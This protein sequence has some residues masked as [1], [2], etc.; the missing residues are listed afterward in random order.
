MSEVDKIRSIVQPYLSGD[1]V[2][3]GFGGN[4]VNTTAIC[5]DLKEPY[6]NYGASRHL[7]G[8]ARS[9]YWFK[10]GVL[11]YVFSSH[12]LEDFPN[13]K[14]ILVEW[15]RVI[16]IGGT[17]ALYLPDERKYSRVLKETGGRY[18]AHHQIGNMSLAYMRGLF[19]E[20]GIIAVYEYVEQGDQMYGFLIV[21]KR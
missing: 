17:I 20:L 16:K 21:G 4:P 5:V 8:D 11:D 9:L 10:D 7:T 14:E 1:G 3:L 15:L 2:D 19:S 6:S 13:T 12:L 18:N